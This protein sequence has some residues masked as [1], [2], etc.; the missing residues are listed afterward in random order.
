MNKT[1]LP[2]KSFEMY[3]IYPD[4]RVK[5]D[6]TDKFLTPITNT[7][8]P[9]YKMVRLSNTR[10]LRVWA[11]IHRL[12]ANAFIPNPSKLPVVNHLDGNSMNND[13]SNLE[14]TTN[15]GN[16]K[17]SYLLGKKSSKGIKNGNA[18]LTDKNVKQIRLEYSTG[19]KEKQIAKKFGVTYTAIYQITRNRTWKAK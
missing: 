5:S 14:W 9:G 3:R 6:I 18:K 8:G 12:V 1:F 7:A 2:V 11:K 13:V 10:G 15:S 17:H 4:G 16:L 19:I